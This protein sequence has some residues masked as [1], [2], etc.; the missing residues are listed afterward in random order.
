VLRE[1]LLEPLVAPQHNETEYEMKNEQGMGFQHRLEIV[2]RRQRAEEVSPM[3]VLEE[4]FEL[5][6]DYGPAWYTK[7]N[8]DRAVAALMQ[9]S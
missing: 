6:E 3:K 8:H 9:H 2:H 1:I 5:L 4:L 7:E